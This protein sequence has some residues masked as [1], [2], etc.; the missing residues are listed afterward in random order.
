MHADPLAA[1]IARRILPGI[2]SEIDPAFGF[3]D[4]AVWTAADAALHADARAQFSGG[5]V[6][7]CHHAATSQ[8]IDAVRIQKALHHGILLFVEYVH[9]PVVVQKRAQGDIRQ[10]KAFVFIQILPGQSGVFRDVRL[11]RR[12]QDVMD[13]SI[14][15][16]VVDDCIL[17]DLFNGHFI[18][19]H[20]A[21][22][23]FLRVSFRAFPFPA[24]IRRQ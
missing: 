22:P 18:D 4:F 21:S 12:H 7:S 15:L 13:H 24:H 16:A 11:C 8:Q 6:N 5:Q 19:G 23:P 14:V 9:R 1:L 2:V 20:P 3:L 10:R 17:F